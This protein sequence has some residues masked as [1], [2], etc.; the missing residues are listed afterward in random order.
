MVLVALRRHRDEPCITSSTK[1]VAALNELKR[2]CSVFVRCKHIIPRVGEAQKRHTD[3]QSCKHQKLF[4]PCV[5]RKRRYSRER[6]FFPLNYTEQK[7]VRLG[8]I[9]IKSSCLFSVPQRC[10][11]GMIRP[12]QCFLCH[13]Q[14]IIWMKSFLFCALWLTGKEILFLSFP[15]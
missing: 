10:W 15:H 9:Q 4:R 8:V 3:S 12:L 7:P 13:L 1:S 14:F 5:E 2:S 11:F 6:G